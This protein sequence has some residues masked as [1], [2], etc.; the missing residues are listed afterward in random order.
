[1]SMTP[2]LGEVAGAAREETD[3]GQ[4]DCLH[5]IISYLHLAIVRTPALTFEKIATAWLSMRS[6]KSGEAS[7]SAPCTA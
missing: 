3:Y 4:Y 5:E 1:M 6:C 7:Q 2:F